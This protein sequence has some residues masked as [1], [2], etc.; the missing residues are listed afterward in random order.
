MAEAKAERGIKC[1]G[2][3]LAH[4]RAHPCEQQYAI[5]YASSLIAPAL[6]R[7]VTL[8]I[9]AC[10]PISANLVKGN[11]RHSSRQI[12]Q[13]VHFSANWLAISSKELTTSTGSRAIHGLPCQI[14]CGAFRTRNVG[15]CDAA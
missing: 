6:R 8:S 14:F 4:T 7:A 1:S 12:P 9:M 15:S 10:G 3:T 2:H 5:S 11:T 13:L